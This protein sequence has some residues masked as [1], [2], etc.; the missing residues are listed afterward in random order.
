M[1][2]NLASELAAVRALFSHIKGPLL[3]GLVAHRG[4]HCRSDA[5]HRPLENTLDA[6]IQAWGAGAKHCECDVSLTA[7]GHIVLLHD[8]DLARLSLFQNH[9]FANVPVQTLTRRDLFECPL[10]NGTSPPLL[11][12]VL[13][14]AHN[15]GD[16]KYLVVEIKSEIG[17]DESRYE[18][19]A[20]KFI[21]DLT[22][23]PHLSKR[24]SVVMSFDPLAVATV[25][26]LFDSVDQSQVKRPLI[27]LLTETNP[28]S[29]HEIS[30]LQL[31]T[32]ANPVDQYS[33]MIDTLCLGAQIDGVYL[34][35][36][37]QMEA[38]QPQ[39]DALLALAK[40]VVVGF[41]DVPDNQAQLSRL[42]EWGARFVNTDLPNE[43]C[44]H[45]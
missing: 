26:R 11:T 20:R 44:D 15:F 6:Y 29:P 14:V 13:T 7:D 41:W 16:D 21:E 30:Q 35:Y 8:N 32:S 34:R 24:V 25:S 31:M 23:F 4:F 10:K 1:A 5:L 45:K 39:H 33:S 19:L 42:V 17:S 22:Q 3:E 12:D 28:T 27:L 43:F 38:G 40:T 9:R 37:S 36:D 2:K 18:P